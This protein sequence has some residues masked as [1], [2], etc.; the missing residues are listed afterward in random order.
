MAG[1]ELSALRS[2][3]RRAV[4]PSSTEPLG[5]A[6]SAAQPEHPASN[7][8][9]LVHVFSNLIGRAFYGPLSARYRLSVQ[10]WRVLLTLA[11]RPGATA[12]DIIA[13]WALQPMSV[14]R[15]IREL[16]LRGL[17]VRRIGSVDRR[18]HELF[19]TRN[20][21]RAYQ[22]V[23]PDAN[24]RYRQVVDC[25]SAAERARLARSLVTLIANTKRLTEEQGDVR[26]RL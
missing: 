10:Q 25:L 11:Q 15:A 14:S 12:A 1:A 26:A 3:A 21:Q 4:A 5:A 2:R 19:L 23:V 24:A 6:A 18:S 13:S 7:I 9:A 17:V 20:G 22:S 8:L 16:E